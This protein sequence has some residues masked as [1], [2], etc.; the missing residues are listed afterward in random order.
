[1]NKATEEAIKSA[2][3]RAPRL[4]SDDEIIGFG[5]FTINGDGRRQLIRELVRDLS[6]GDV[7][8]VLEEC[9]RRAMEIRQ[10]REHRRDQR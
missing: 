10:I 6:M 1:M 3:E 8:F 9:M 2:A 5:H 4:D 7:K